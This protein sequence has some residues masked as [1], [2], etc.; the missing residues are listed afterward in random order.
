MNIR[1]SI[2]RPLSNSTINN[3]NHNKTF[4]NY[5]SV[6]PLQEKNMINLS[7]V[8]DYFENK[9]EK[10]KYKL[11]N[12]TKKCIQ[13]NI[14]NNNNSYNY[15]NYNY[16]N[17]NCN[18]YN[19]Y[20]LRSQ[21][22]LNSSL[23]TNEKIENNNNNKNNKIKTKN[24]I[25]INTNPQ[26]IPEYIEDIY[27]YFKEISF[28]LKPLYGYME[29]IQTD[30][31][32]KMRS[33]LIDWLIEVHLKFKLTPET[34]YLTINLIDIY[35]SKVNI[36]R[37]KLQLIGI[38]CL[39][40]CN[41]YEE[42][43]PPDLK[44]HIE[45]TDHAY[46]KKEILEM[47][48][49]ILKKLEFNITFPTCYR[50]LEIFFQILFIYNNYEFKNK[51]KFFMFCR[52]LI[53]LS[54]LDYKMLKYTNSEIGIS[55]LYLGYKICEINNIELNLNDFILIFNN[56]FEIEKIQNCVKDLCNLLENQDNK[57][58]KNEN[59]KLQSVYNKFMRKDY[60]S[61]ADWKN[62]NNQIYKD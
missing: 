50:Y 36:N 25:I 19:N 40:I 58:F 20:C 9:K 22:K 15:Y 12:K 32:S 46:N 45:M 29:K 6:K 51:N 44:E 11:K 30:I 18:N 21:I 59:H 56:I 38:T 3:I 35:L 57:I 43:Y 5:K 33:I 27:N 34:L 39:F 4:I 53:E 7:N 2:R 49:E 54:L 31:N 1:F 13:K 62:I 48:N 55:S 24:K 14:L 26:L 28:N 8:L 37:N 52:Y 47:E 60:L 23:S 16:N 61:V 42:I 17:N 10:S 41:K